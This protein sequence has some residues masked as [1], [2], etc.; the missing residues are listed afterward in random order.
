MSERDKILGRVREALRVTAPRPGAEPGHAAAPAMVGRGRE[1]LPAV[2]PAAAE[3]RACFARN[4]SVLKA[5]FHWMET[6][7][8]AHEI[9]RGVADR[10]GW[11]RIAAHGSGAAATAAAALGLPVLTTDGGY[12]VRELERCDAGISECDALVAQT[13]SVLVTSKSA[14]GGHSR[15]FR[16]ITWSSPVATNWYPTSRPPL[17]CSTTA[18]PGPGPA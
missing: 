10:A 5:E 14:G 12:D 4:A 17:N 3:W 1:W 6:A 18:T 9:V 13:G 11:R 8:A 7:E 16:R 2:P 15:S